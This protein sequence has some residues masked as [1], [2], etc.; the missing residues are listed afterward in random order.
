MVGV[1]IRMKLAVLRHA[2]T[3]ERAGWPVAG[4]VVGLVL[5]GGT[6]W[7]AALPVA[8]AGADSGVLVDLLALAF[9]MWTAGWLVGPIWG[10]E[11]VLRPDQ[12]ALLPIPRVWLAVGL[13]GAAFVGVTTAVTLVGFAA[14][15]VYGARLGVVAAVVAVPA[16]L[17]QLVFVVALS[18]V[19]TSVFGAASRSRAGGV[20]VA[21]ITAAVM[22][23]T[24]WGWLVVLVVGE[25]G[26]LTAGLPPG[27]SAV[28]RALP[29]SWAVVAVHAA[30]A[31][32][33]AA[34]GA[35]LLGL[36]ALVV[37]LVLVWGRLLGLPRS[38]RVVVRGSARRPAF[39]SRLLST[40]SGP[41]FVKELR[42]WWRDPNRTLALVTGSAFGL[43][44]ALLPLAIGSTALMPWAGALAVTMTVTFCGN[45][46]AQDGTALW[47]TLLDP[48]S[49][50][51]DVR[52]RQ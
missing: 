28:V 8:G 3:G 16:A 12:F 34:A 27:L 24:Q 35:A 4:G 19:A 17:L 2:M 31:A 25:S 52:G 13:L 37:A 32:D 9:T 10:G 26:V 23:L 50:R 30:G 33:W 6:I 40:G 42:T 18:R 5:A 1:L 21:L 14:L 51:A 41:V 29:S 22:V 36:V 47:L 11:P 38:G 44:V 15:V 49:E 43:M 45:L 39:R 48:G 46:Y 20:V 7:L